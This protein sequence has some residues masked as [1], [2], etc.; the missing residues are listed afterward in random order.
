MPSWQ[1]SV[2][3]RPPRD[4]A[5]R[6]D[7]LEISTELAGRLHIVGTAAW[8]ADDV[9]GTLGGLINPNL[10]H[11]LEQ[12]TGTL[13]DQ[14]AG[15]RGRCDVAASAVFLGILNVLVSALAF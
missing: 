15:F 2:S 4:R 7:A 9:V 3:R 5:D 13:I 12:L 1:N 8:L 6:A 14:Y 10:G 11:G